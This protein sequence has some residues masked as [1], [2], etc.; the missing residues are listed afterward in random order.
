MEE[1]TYNAVEFNDII[2]ASKEPEDIIDKITNRGRFYAYCLEK[3][4]VC[5]NAVCNWRDEG[6]YNDNLCA[7]IRNADDFNAIKPLLDDGKVYIVS[8][9]RHEG[10]RLYSHQGPDYKFV[11]NDASGIARAM[12]EQLCDY[13]VAQDNVAH[14]STEELARREEMEIPENI[15][16]A[17]YWD[18]N[19][20]FLISDTSIKSGIWQYYFDNKE[21]RV[22]AVFRALIDL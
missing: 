10:R 12:A 19:G 8:A 14:Y 20:N 2:T 3:G 21:E 22:L 9:T 13:L 4:L 1:R 6:Q 17:G 5:T 11:E 16:E 18:E 15:D 7:I